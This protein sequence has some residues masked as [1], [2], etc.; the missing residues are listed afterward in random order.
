MNLSELIEENNEYCIEIKKYNKNISK[1]NTVE[2][3]KVKQ[4]FELINEVLPNIQNHHIKKLLFN[5]DN[6]LIII[7]ESKAYFYNIYFQ[8]Q[9]VL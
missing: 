5:S 9:K 7:T 3:Q 1:N 4:I 8:K 6:S 2:Y